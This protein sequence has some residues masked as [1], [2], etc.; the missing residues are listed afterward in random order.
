M[1]YRIT[2]TLH[3]VPCVQPDCCLYGGI[4][5]ED[6]YSIFLSVYLRGLATCSQT[7]YKAV[8]FD[9]H[10]RNGSACACSFFRWCVVESHFPFIFCS[11]AIQGDK[12]D[13]TRALKT[14]KK[15]TGD[16][17]FEEPGWNDAELN[18]NHRL[19]HGAL[20]RSFYG[21]PL[22]N[23]PHAL[24]ASRSYDASCPHK[25]IWID[26]IAL[27]AIPACFVVFF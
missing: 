11:T 13:F 12:L 23:T 22:K 24:S 1:P 4:E 3:L 18:D 27:L 20:I 8:T 21:S 9:Q 5:T 14:N 17:H 6:W 2:L 15:R 26:L 10:Y 16:I 25:S 7:Q 19:L